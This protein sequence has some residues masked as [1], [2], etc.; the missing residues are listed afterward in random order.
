M[1]N[2]DLAVRPHDETALAITSGTENLDRSDLVI[3]R[4]RL[5]Q[6]QSMFS[7]DVGSLYNSLTGIAKQEVKAVIL[8]V[9]KARVR[10]PDDFQRDQLPEC[11]SNDGIVPRDDFA[12]VFSERCCT[13]AEALW[14]DDQPPRCALSYVYLLA[15]RENDLPA[16]LSVSRSSLKAA[17]QMNTLIRAFGV[18]REIIIG[19]QQVTNERGKYHV[20]TFRLGDP[21]AP[22]EVVKY[23][24]MSAALGG[25][26]LTADTGE[27]N[28]AGEAEDEPLEF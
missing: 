28:G 3:P 16:M 18:R 13:C 11:A 6:A 27:D 2:T 17:R 22:D 5:V 4:L 14:L 19:S 9:G 24:A 15:D 25:V 20:L 12:G 7:D 1:S 10:W 21:I 8:K 23:A 26:V